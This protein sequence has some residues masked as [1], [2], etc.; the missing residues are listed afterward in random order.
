[1]KETK[2][3]LKEQGLQG[4]VGSK[5][6]DMSKDIGWKEKEMEKQKQNVST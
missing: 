4:L 2:G 6:K 1:M 3:I 5:G